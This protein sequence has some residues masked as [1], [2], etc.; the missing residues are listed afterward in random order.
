GDVVSFE[1][2]GTTYS[3]TVAADGKWS[4]QVAGA[5]LAAESNIHAT[6]KAHDEAGNAV[7]V[8]ADRPYTV[9]TQPLFP[10]L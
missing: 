5:D 4:V 2:N 6:L 7:D 1:L 10:S 3:A 9:I 8:E